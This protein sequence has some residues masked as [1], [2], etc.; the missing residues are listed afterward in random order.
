MVNPRRVVQR[1]LGNDTVDSKSIARELSNK[2]EGGIGYS[3]K[4]L[5]QIAEE[6]IEKHYSHINDKEKLIDEVYEYLKGGESS[7]LKH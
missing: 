5:K 6:Y 2:M 4:D 3:W 1:I 7:Q